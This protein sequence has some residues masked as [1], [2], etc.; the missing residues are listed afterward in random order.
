MKMMKKAIVLV[1]AVLSMLFL[2]GCDKSAQISTDLNIKED[3]SGERTMVITMNKTNFAENVTGTIDDIKTIFTES[4]PAELTYE[5]SETE[6]DY[7]V[8]V[9]LA[10]TSFDDYYTKVATITGTEEPGEAAITDSVFNSGITVDENFSSASLMQWLKDKVLEKGMVSSGNS[11][12]VFEDNGG[13]VTYGETTYNVGNN[14]D[15]NETVSYP[16]DYIS[17]KTAYNTDGTYD[18]SI[19]FYIPQ[20]TMDANGEAIKAFF[21]EDL[22]GGATCDFKKDG[23]DD[24]ATCEFIIEGVIADVI[25]S[26]TKSVFHSENCTVKETKLDEKNTLLSQNAV[27]EESFDL[28]QFVSGYYSE[29]DFR[30][31]LADE[32]VIVKDTYYNEEEKVWSDNGSSYQIS[33][34]ED[35][36]VQETQISSS[37]GMTFDS[38]LNYVAYE[39][40]E[41]IEF[42]TKVK[43]ND[44]LDRTFTLDFSKELSD[45]VRK[46]L[47]EKAEEIVGKDGKVKT[48][49]K[50]DKYS[51]II[52]LNGETKEIAKTYEKIF[53]SEMDVKYGVEHNWMGAKNSFAYEENVN[54][55]Q[56]LPFS[57]EFKNKVD[58]GL[59][60]KVQ[61]DLSAEYVKKGST[62]TYTGMTDTA[63]S[64]TLCGTKTNVIGMLSI[65]FLILVI[66]GLGVFAF[67]IITDIVKKQGEKKA[68]MQAAQPF[69]QPGVMSQQFVQSV[70]QP[71]VQP[72]AESQQPVEQEQVAQEQVAVTAEPTVEVPVVESQAENSVQEVSLFCPEC[73]TKFEEEG[74][75]FCA[76]CG[77]KRQ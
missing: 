58:F 29:V 69:V 7:I 67:L 45:G 62:A 48:K 50:D 18:R 35:G 37:Y 72:V 68:A 27:L 73:G 3:F 23:Y 36:E 59:G 57:V 10:F 61:N 1:I 31:C 75:M 15:L 40:P 25:E 42:E 77:A 65:V 56:F 16:L 8:T 46:S 28:S 30:Y 9:H 41:A 44:K 5:F 22:V 47:K 4:C 34:N 14:I 54:L 11:S 53:G 63:A 21:E 17:M 38:T 19:T 39:I 20:D 43:G 33:K 76:N 52:T 70:P 2:V 74:A 12:Y 13:T 64:I 71:V 49:E 66:V 6:T 55:T 51:L 24:G 60:A 32:G 26:F